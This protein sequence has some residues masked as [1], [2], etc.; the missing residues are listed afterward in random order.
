[1]VPGQ[2][3]HG[4]HEGGLVPGRIAMALGQAWIAVIPVP[5]QGKI[6]DKPR[7]SWFP[8]NVASAC[9]R[10]HERAD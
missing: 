2:F 6:C 3:Q 7:G 1:M 10:S 8:G 5:R 4:R 9:E